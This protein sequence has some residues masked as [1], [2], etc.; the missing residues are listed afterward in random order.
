MTEVPP[1]LWIV[2]TLVAA[3][4]QSMRNAMQRGLI[5]EIGTVAATHVRFLFGLP[6]VVLAAIAMVLLTGKALPIPSWTG[7]VWLIFGAFSQIGGTALLLT[8]MRERSFVVATTYSKVEPVLVAVFGLVFLGEFLSPG[9]ALAVLMATAGVMITGWPKTTGDMLLS[10]QSIVFG[11][12]SAALFAMAAVGYRGAIVAMPG[13]NFV[14]RATAAL[15]Y[16]ITLQTVVLSI[17]LAIRDRD[18]LI[19]MA[20][21]WRQSLSAGFFGAFASEL[22]F[23]AFAIEQVARI[24]TLALVEIL[25]GYFLSRKLFS[26]G[27]SRREIAGMALIAL[28]VA[29]LLNL[30]RSG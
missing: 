8:V 1:W 14:L 6:F 2:I 13:D 12:G 21:A 25:F 9:M 10:R 5:K 19:A 28:G 20:R 16:A 11:V 7:F 24:R 26:E 17:W 15:L 29:L 3:G 4:A 22:W 18:K 30:P 27:V 23:L